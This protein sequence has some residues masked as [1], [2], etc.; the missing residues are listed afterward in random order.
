MKDQLPTIY[1]SEVLDKM[2]NKKV[3]KTV[4][5]AK[6]ATHAE[7]FS[8]E[9]LNCRLLPLS[10]NLERMIALGPI[11]ERNVWSVGIKNV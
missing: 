3:L 9:F 6:A 1:T 8:E 11:L 5:Q 7:D 10:A 2:T 4:L